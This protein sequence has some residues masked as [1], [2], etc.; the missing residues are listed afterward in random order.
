[1]SQVVQQEALTRLLVERGLFTNEEFLEMA[2]VVDQEMKKRQ[3]QREG[4]PTGRSLP[5][6]SFIKETFEYRP[7]FK[8]WLF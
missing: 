7:H 5:K 1:L 8:I 3:I 6:D 2:K 4:V